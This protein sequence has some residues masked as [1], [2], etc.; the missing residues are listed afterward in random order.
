MAD[1]AG[2]LSM[3][4]DWIQNV[5]MSM[6][7]DRCRLHGGSHCIDTLLT[8]F[9]SGRAL[10]SSNYTGSYAFE[11]II[12]GITESIREHLPHGCD[13]TIVSASDYSPA[14]II[15]GRAWPAHFGATMITGDH[16]DRL[17]PSVKAKLKKMVAR[18]PEVPRSSRQE[19]G[20]T[21]VAKVRKCIEAGAFE[22]TAT[23]Y[24]HKAETHVRFFEIS[25]AIALGCPDAIDLGAAGSTCD[26]HSPIGNH[27]GSCHSTIAELLAWMAEMKYLKK[28]I[29]FHECGVNFDASI[30]E[31]A[32]EP[33]YIPITL[34]M[35]GNDIGHPYGRRRV[36]QAFVLAEEYAPTA[37]AD[38]LIYW[39]KRRVGVTSVTTTTRKM[40][41][42]KKISAIEPHG[43]PSFGQTITVLVSTKFLSPSL[44]YGGQIS[45][46]RKQR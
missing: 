3:E 8:H 17:R 11:Q 44:R 40:Q 36:L 28:K 32:A 42:C 39:M 30:T 24:C 5:L 13:V 20:D 6:R 15:I 18:L 22:E 46:M 45:P 23:V 16:M 1:M 37:T 19:V 9:R 35:G 21:V 4:E 43:S 41:K 25:R 27:A 29:F 2:I 26:A 34:K 31:A 38:Q 33:E 12:R 10:V 7:S 14:S